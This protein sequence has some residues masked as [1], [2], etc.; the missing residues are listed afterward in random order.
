V[1]EEKRTLLTKVTAAA[2]PKIDYIS[3]KYVLGTH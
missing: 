3:Y 2:P 1:K